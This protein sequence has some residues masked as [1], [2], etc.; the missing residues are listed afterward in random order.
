MAKVKNGKV[1]LSRWEEITDIRFFC[2][3]FLI[4]A[5]ISGMAGYGMSQDNIDEYNQTH[6]CFLN[7]SI[8]PEQECWNET[9]NIT[10]I[11]SDIYK[12]G[13]E[14]VGSYE[15]M[16]NFSE[17][18]RKAIEFYKDLDGKN[19]TKCTPK[20]I[21]ECVEW[22][23]VSVCKLHD[24]Y[25]LALFVDCQGNCADNNPDSLSYRN[26]EE[27]C[28]INYCDVPCKKWEYNFEV[29]E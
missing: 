13:I 7:S 22:S 26:C 10:D 23:P 9:I 1:Y 28:T 21:K 2:T 4:V 6:I 24:S 5:T 27:K 12:A 17:Y 18:M 8:I 3:V 20:P 15:E 16:V 19:I 29:K 25:S 14:N 11:L